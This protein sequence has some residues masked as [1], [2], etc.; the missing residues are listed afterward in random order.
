MPPASPR[1]EATPGHP[2]APDRWQ[3]FGVRESIG[4]TID[5]LPMGC[6]VCDMP[7]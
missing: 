4:I 5:G 3:T 7:S 1:D 2:R 6:D